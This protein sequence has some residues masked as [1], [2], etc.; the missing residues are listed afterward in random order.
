MRH[1]TPHFQHIFSGERLRRR[2]L[3]LSLVGGARRRRLRRLR[4][5]RRRLRPGDGETAARLHLFRRQ[6]PRPG[7]GLRRLPRPRTPTRPR[8][9]GNAGSMC[10]PESMTRRRGRRDLLTREVEGGNAKS[11]RPGAK[12]LFTVGKLDGRRFAH[13]HSRPFLRTGGFRHGSQRSLRRRHR[14]DIARGAFELAVA[15]GHKVSVFNR[16]RANAGLPAG[17]TT[18]VGDMNDAAAYGALAKARFDVGLP[19]HGLHAR[20]DGARHRDLH[21]PHRRSTSSSPRPRS[22]R[23]RR[24]TT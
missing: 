5:G 15:A 3:Q 17:V 11:G 21:R 7:G 24:A 19:V 6:P 20:A 8:S 23:S 9:C 2:L 18:I 12:S 22:T 13:V 14:P 1:R 16:G 10:S 4:G